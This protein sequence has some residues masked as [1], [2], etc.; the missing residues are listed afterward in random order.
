MLAKVIFEYF[1]L[2][3]LSMCLFIP[4][5]VRQTT[6]KFSLLY[7][8]ISSFGTFLH[9]SKLTTLSF[10]FCVDTLYLFYILLVVNFFQFCLGWCYLPTL[11]YLGIG[12]VFIILKVSNQLCK[13]QWLKILGHIGRCLDVLYKIMFLFSP[14]A[15]F[16]WKCLSFVEMLFHTKHNN[17]LLYLQRTSYSWYVLNIFMSMEFFWKLPNY[18]WS[19]ESGP[20]FDSSLL[21]DQVS[22]NDNL[23]IWLGSWILW[24]Q[25]ITFFFKFSI[26][27]AYY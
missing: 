22:K 12:K 6:W 1:Q 23:K 9:S 14:L 15:R 11:K 3:S 17:I 24:C 4:F 21:K 18:L 25:F 13:K 2:L 7:G 8:V 10:M 26:I 20:R 27:K 5:N 19:L 16:V